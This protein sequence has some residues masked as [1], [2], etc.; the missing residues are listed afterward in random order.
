MTKHEKENISNLMVQSPK[1]FLQVLLHYSE[2]KF[3]HIHIHLCTHIH[4]YTYT[5]TYTCAI[6]ICI[7]YAYMNMYVYVYTGAI[8]TCIVYTCIMFMDTTGVMGNCDVNS[9]SSGI[10]NLEFILGQFLYLLLTSLQLL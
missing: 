5:Y 10:T 7:V 1:A 6:S 8:S 2:V 9:T 3:M 4:V